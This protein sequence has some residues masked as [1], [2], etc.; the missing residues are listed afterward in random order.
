M[1]LDAGPDSVGWEHQ[2]WT[3]VRIAE[4]VRERFGM[5]QPLPERDLL[6]RLRWS[7]QVPARQAGVSPRAVGGTVT[8]TAWSPS[9]ETCAINVLTA[10]GPRRPTLR[11]ADGPLL[12]RRPGD[13]HHGRGVADVRP[14]LTTAQPTL[15]RWR[16]VSAALAWAR[17]P[18]GS[19]RALC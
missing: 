18:P 17:G 12:R 6:H 4:L 2:C 8:S 1:L 14:S 9:A 15:R 13:V 16:G 10:D 5:H 19:C 11:V 3:L 7:M